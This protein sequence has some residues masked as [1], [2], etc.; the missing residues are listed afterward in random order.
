MGIS[1]LLIEC[2]FVGLATAIF[3]LIISYLIKPNSTF[4]I[5][6]LG[7]VTGF[8]IH[9]LLDLIGINKYYCNNGYSCKK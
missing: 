5:L 4:K 2:V 6:L 1:Q 9:F 8:L 3:L 7:F